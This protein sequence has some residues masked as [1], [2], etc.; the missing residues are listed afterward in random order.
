MVKGRRAAIR[1]LTYALANRVVDSL[2]QKD[3]RALLEFLRGCY[4]VSDL[5]GFVAR[6]L[7]DLPQLVPADTTVYNEYNFKRNRIIWQEN[8]PIAFP[9]SE[10]IWERYSREHPILDHIRRTKDGRAVKFS[11][12]VT[13]RQFQRTGLYSE[14]FLPLRIE[15][16]MHVLFG[17]PKNLLVGLALN[18]KKTDFSERD[19]TILNL[20]RPHLLRAYQNAAVLTEMLQEMAALRCAIEDLHRGVIV[21]SPNRKIKSINETARSWLSEYFG[22]NQIRGHRLPRELDLRAARQRGPVEANV[23]AHR[24]APAPV[25]IVERAGKQLRAGLIAAAGQSVVIL[26][27][28]RLSIDPPALR[29]LGL[30][31][32]ETEVLTWMAQGKTNAEIGAILHTRPRTVE[33][34]IERILDKLGVETRTGAVGAALRSV[35]A[36]VR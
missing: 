8:P 23:A 6:I 7:A 16:Q 2:T 29:F 32:R 13:R 12:F 24:P 3:F 35:E 15:H 26:E 33:K 31:Q 20:L 17:E 11:D 4:A 10:R 21:L 5:D 28:R 19:R 22:D 30:T 36:P 1:I 25:W 18:R 9:G 34:H 14:F 27:D